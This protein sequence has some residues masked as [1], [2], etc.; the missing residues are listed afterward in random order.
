MARL[1]T[2]P[3]G[4]TIANNV[5]I[6]LRRKP[7]AP[8]EPAKARCLASL[9]LLG[10]RPRLPQGIVFGLEPLVFVPQDVVTGPTGLFARDSLYHALGMC[11]DGG[12]TVATLG[13][14]PRHRSPRATEDG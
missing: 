1:G 11:V 2:A 13:R 3:S 4:N 14:A 10:F 5:T 9:K 7:M 8:P 12:A 6:W